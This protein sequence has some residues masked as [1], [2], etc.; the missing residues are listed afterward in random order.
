M[1]LGELRMKRYV[2]ESMNC[3]GIARLACVARSR[4]A[5]D[6]LRIENAVANDSKFAGSLGDEHRT[7]RK[8]G[9]APWICQTTSDCDDANA[10]AFGRIELHRQ[11]RERPIGEA[12]RRDRDVISKRHLLLKQGRHY[13]VRK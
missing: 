8:E 1:I 5:S 12:C 10:L 7:I 13:D 4:N 6:R 9:H 11:F 2:H 3:A